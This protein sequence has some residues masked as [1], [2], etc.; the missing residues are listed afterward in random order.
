MSFAYFLSQDGSTKVMMD[1]VKRV[2]IDLP[3]SVSQ[4]SNSAGQAISHTSVEGNAIISMEGR[5]TYSKSRIQEDNL[6]PVQFQQ[7]IQKAR[8]GRHKFTLY[9]ATEFNSLL[10]DY[11]NC[12]IQNVNVSIGDY[13]DS[14]DVNITFE[15]VFVSDSAEVTTIKISPSDQAK[16]E[17]AASQDSSEKD[18]TKTS[19]KEEQKSTI[20]QSSA[21]FLTGNDDFNVTALFED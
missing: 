6:N 14:I 1:M 17:G 8:R 4:S 12:V 16:L 7:E 13:T 21:A 19:A 10:Q 2:N 11:K 5:V 20:L 15:Q 18:G 3:S 9:L